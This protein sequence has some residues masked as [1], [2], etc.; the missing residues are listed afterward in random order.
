MGAWMGAVPIILVVLL[1]LV[2]LLLALPMAVAFR[3]E[4]MQAFKGEIA[5]HCLFGRVCY[6]L[7]VPGGGAPT[8]EAYPAVRAGRASTKPEPRKR[9]PRQ[10]LALL[11][12]AAF[13]QRIYRLAQDLADAIH[14][15]RLRLNMRVGLGDP[16]DTGCLWALVG[17]LQ[18][19]AQ[20]LHGANVRIEPEFMD[21]V[22]EFRAQGRLVVRPLQLLFV[23]M[24]FALSPA[25]IRAWRTLRASHA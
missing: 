14:L 25:S 7:Q 4:G 13:R 22:F 12:Q 3:I 1:G 18:A 9:Q 19:V 2:V 16:A 6:R 15:R 11:R 21:A 8:P 20:N 10:V 17:P 5:V 24:G 23:V